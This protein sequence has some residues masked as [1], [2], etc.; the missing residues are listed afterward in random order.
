VACRAKAGAIWTA[1]ARTCS[2][3][4]GRNI[5]SYL[6]STGLGGASSTLIDYLS[7]VRTQ[8]ATAHQWNTALS[9]AAVDAYLR[10][11]HSRSGHPFTYGSACP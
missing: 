3:F 1:R 10:S 7:L 8:A 9:V 2:R 4:A 11:G 5:T 6:S